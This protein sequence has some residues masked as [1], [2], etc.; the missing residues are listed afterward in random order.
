QCACSP[1]RWPTQL[2][3]ASRQS[4]KARP[5]SANLLK[6]RKPPAPQ[7]DQRLRAIVLKKVTVAVV[8][9][10]VGTGA[11]AVTVEADAAL[12]MFRRGRLRF[13]NPSFLKQPQH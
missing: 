10:A 3:K 13:P 8:D 5:R 12:P 9:A 4:K 1:P 2:S 6:R 7:A 11:I